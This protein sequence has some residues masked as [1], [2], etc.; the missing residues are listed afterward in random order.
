MGFK[1]LL[2]ILEV[3]TILYYLGFPV[4]KGRPLFLREFSN[5][6]VVLILFSTLGLIYS[7]VFVVLGILIGVIIYLFVRIWFVVGVN[8]EQIKNA[9][10]KALQ[11]TRSEFQLDKERYVVPG[12]LEISMKKIGALNIIRFYPHQLT[13][14]QNLI[15]NL[16]RKLIENYRISF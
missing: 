14:K 1:L 8:T 15:R 2:L 6:L 3:I 5:A 13:R 11:M 4:I 7:L 16:F 9:L 10:E 12:L